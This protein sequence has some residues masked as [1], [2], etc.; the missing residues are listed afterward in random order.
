M[1]EGNLWVGTSE[2][3]NC[4]KDGAVTATLT[5]KDGLPGNSI[6]ALCADRKGNLWIGTSEGLAVRSAGRVETPYNEANGLTERFIRTAL[7]RP[8]GQPV[9]WHLWRIV[10]RGA[11]PSDAAG[12][13]G[14]GHCVPQLNA[15][16]AAYD[17]VMSIVQDEEGSLWVGSRDGLSRLRV[18][19]FA[20]LGKP[21]GLSQNSVTSVCEDT[22]GAL[23]VTTWRGGLDRL[24]D[25][26]LFTYSAT[27]GLATDLLLSLCPGH[28][29]SVW[30]GADHAGGLYR[31]KDEVFSHFD[32]R[33]G[34]TN[35]A[36]QV[37]YEDSR[38]NLWIGTPKTLTLFTGGKFIDF[39]PRDG[40][41]GEAVKAILE[42]HAGNLW[43][44]TSTGLS[45]RKDGRF[46][47]F[48]TRDGLSAQLH[49][50]PLRRRGDQP[51]DWHG[52][53]RP[54]PAARRPV[55]ALT[56]PGRASSATRCWR[57]WKTTPAACG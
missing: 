50:V 56:P 30:I 1:R 53:R 42:D 20:G 46:A 3:L 49:H 21:Q 37:I 34:L 23:W 31:F 38:T 48:S 43:I 45:C 32:A 39:T 28:D 7:R 10:P 26:K 33:H 14:H 13:L 11:E 2:G 29:G 16:G 51:L 27:N 52:G 12:Q 25:G 41:A 40:L 4:I 44:G 54:E 55:H 57:S 22:S 19:P 24:T 47:N 35:V 8:P 5:A 6:T 15:E 9:D 17:R 18:R 36:I